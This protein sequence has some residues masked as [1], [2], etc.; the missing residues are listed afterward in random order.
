MLNESQKARKTQKIR[1][2]LVT[3]ADTMNFL[4]WQVHDD[5]AAITEWHGRLNRSNVGAWQRAQAAEPT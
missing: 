3:E 4:I 1:H 5:L 2:M